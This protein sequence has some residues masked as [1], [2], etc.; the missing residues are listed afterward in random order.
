MTTTGRILIIDDD[1]DFVA[2]YRENFEG[3][4][5]TVHVTHSSDEA[6]KFLESAAAADIDVVLLDQKL[7]GPGG[8]NTGLDLIARIG[9]LAPLA[10]IIVVTGYATPDAIE[11]AFGLGVYDYLVKNGAFDALLRA[12][13]RNAIEVTS[14]RRLATL[15]TARLETTLRSTW[16]AAMAETDANRKGRLL[17]ELV[18]LLFKATPGFERVSTE[19]HTRDEQIDVV[20]ENR[21]D[22]PVWRKDG[23]TYLLG[24]CKHWSSPCGAPEF[25]NFYEKL[26]T[27]YQRARTGFI[28]AVGGFARTFFEARAKKEMAEVVV[29]AID[30]DDLERWVEATDR[31]AILSEL[32]QKA[33]LGSAPLA[34][35]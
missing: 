9:V 25:R 3:Q 28:V 21:S 31:L 11:R 20:V 35:L 7:Q 10:K 15:S 29:V 26:T 1:R 23:S 4:G 16:S 32:Y 34:A 13:V 5:L 8:P 30:R 24:E 19:L 12:K 14:E 17:E 27:K 6:T 2:I 22:D 33:V 18:K